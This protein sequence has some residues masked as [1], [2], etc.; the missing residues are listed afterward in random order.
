[1]QYETDT[2]LETINAETVAN[3]QGGEQSSKDIVSLYPIVALNVGKNALNDNATAMLP[4]VTASHQTFQSA[5]AKRRPI[6]II[7]WG[8]FGIFCSSLRN[9]D[10]DSENMRR[11]SPTPV[12]SAMRCRASERSADVSQPE[13]VSGKSGRMNIEQI[14]T[15][16]VREPSTKNNHLLEPLVKSCSSR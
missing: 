11:S 7:S 6:C 8:C 3:I 12:S 1:M 15:K 13:G 4:I 5:S 16:T 14:A 2:H 10:S 9:P